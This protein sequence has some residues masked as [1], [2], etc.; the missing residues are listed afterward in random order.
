MQIL[1]LMRQGGGE[2]TTNLKIFGKQEGKGEKE[3]R[4]K[5]GLNPLAK[6]MWRVLHVREVHSPSLGEEKKERRAD[7][8]STS[9]NL[10]LFSPK[11][12]EK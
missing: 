6:K 8:A 3:R 12:L 5:S 10:Q 9:G 4:E 7:G 2:R 1:C 11:S